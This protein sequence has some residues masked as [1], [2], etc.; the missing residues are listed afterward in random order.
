M[1]FS[2]LVYALA[3]SAPG[4]VE[5]VYARGVY[6]VV[7]RI[8]HAAFGWAPWSWAEL[9]LLGALGLLTVRAVG[10]SHGA[11]RGRLTW[12]RA[13]WTW[14]RGV[15]LGLCA[16]TTGLILLW[17]LNGRRQSLP[18]LL[19]WEVRPAP[20]AELDA[21]AEE[22]G[23]EVA[24]LVEAPRVAPDLRRAGLG[25]EALRPRCPWLGPVQSRPKRPLIR[26]LL[27]WGSAGGVFSPLTGEPHVNPTA[28]SWLQPE[29]ASHEL[30]HQ[31]GFAR[32]D[33]ANWLGWAACRVHPDPA[34]RYAGALR[35]FQ[36]V[37]GAL[38]RLRPERA[39]ALRRA[40][41]EVARADLREAIHWAQALDGPVQRA[42][43]ATYDRALKASGQTAGLATYGRAVDLLLAE[44]RL[45]GAS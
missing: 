28:P 41:P 13:A 42:A 8:L 1:G 6:P 43:L 38:W 45:R 18:V 15:L 19:G 33:E 2:L 16:A 25:L 37:T 7:A 29:I 32:E 27:D 23:V 22:L 14:V 17:G 40:L 44:R 3:S 36:M 21:L 30:A 31:A 10:L 5:A 24:R 9:G 39:L 35:S 12:G 11:I 4:W 34:F 26:P 20:V